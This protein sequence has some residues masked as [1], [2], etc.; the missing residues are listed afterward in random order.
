MLEVPDPKRTAPLVSR[1]LRNFVR[2]ILANAW[3]YYDQFG[4]PIPANS[5][6]SRSLKISP[7]SKRRMSELKN[8]IKDLNKRF[9]NVLLEPL[10]YVYA[11]EFQERGAVHY[12]FVLLNFPFMDKVFSKIRDLWPDRFELKTIS[13][14]TDIERVI[15]YITKYLSKQTT[16]GRF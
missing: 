10:K 9:E 11:I 13:K 6:L 1:A 8:L 3:R 14:T 16:D 2:I 5:L 15:R 12:H 7:T 4:N